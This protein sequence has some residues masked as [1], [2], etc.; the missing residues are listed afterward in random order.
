VFIVTQHPM[1]IGSLVALTFSVPSAKQLV[2]EESRL[3]LQAKVVR[4]TDA[5]YGLAFVTPAA[6]AVAAIFRLVA[7]SATKV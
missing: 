4:K 5:G 3:R 1:E 7:E 6:D 2:V